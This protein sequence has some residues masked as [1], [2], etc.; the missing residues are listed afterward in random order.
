MIEDNLAKA[1]VTADDVWAK[2]RAANVRHYADVDAVVLERQA[3]AASCT[4]RTA[5]TRPSQRRGRTAPQALPE[6]SLTRNPLP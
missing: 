4:I 3:T 6:R 2:L 1:R 5:R